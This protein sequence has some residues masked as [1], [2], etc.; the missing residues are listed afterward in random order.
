MNTEA[1]KTAERLARLIEENK[2]LRGALSGPEDQ[3]VLVRHSGLGPTIVVPVGNDKTFALSSERGHDF[4]MMPSEYYLE[5]RHRSLFFE[6]GYLYTDDDLE[7][8]DNPNLILDIEEWYEARTERQIAKELEKID[9]PGTLIALY[10]FTQD[11]KEGKAMATR[12]RLATKINETLGVVM[13]ED[14]EA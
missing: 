12:S 7:K 5:L 9:S 4:V 11:K 8:N 10:N 14:T 1:S 2:M 3:K 13:Q 6:N